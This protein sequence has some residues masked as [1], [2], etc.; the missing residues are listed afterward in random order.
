[1]QKLFDEYPSLRQDDKIKTYSFLNF[2]LFDYYKCRRST[3]RTV[4]QVRS[5]DQVAG[6][7]VKRLNVEQAMQG[8]N[9]RLLKGLGF[10]STAQPFQDFL[11]QNG[12]DE[13]EVTPKRADTI[14]K[15]KN[16]GSSHKGWKEAKH[17]R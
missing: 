7:T 5:E 1:M 16:V 12:I 14:A 4:E 17:H 11:E 10:G 6:I 9:K 15:D 3:D 8:I 13:M 2:A